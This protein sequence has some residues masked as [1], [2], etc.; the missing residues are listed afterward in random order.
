MLVAA[1]L[2]RIGSDESARAAHLVQA[3]VR[4]CELHGRDIELTLRGTVRQFELPRWSIIA[5]AIMT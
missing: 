5:L 3:H 4:F 1:A 2:M